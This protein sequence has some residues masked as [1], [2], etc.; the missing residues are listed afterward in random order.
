[1]TKVIKINPH[2]PEKDKI[3]QAAGVLQNGG[4]VIFPTETVYGVAANMQNAKAMDRLYKIK[5]RPKDKPFSIHIDSKEKVELYARDIPTS[6]YKLMNKFWP[7]PLTIILK[8]NSG[9]T[10]GFRL[11]DCAIATELIKNA[12]VAVVAPSANLS[13]SPA[14]ITFQDAIKDLEGKVDL[15]IDAGPAKIGLESSV[16]DLTCGHALVMREAAIKKED[17]EKV[18]N[19]KTV[20]FVCTGNTCRSVMAKYLM[21][22]ILKD[23]GRNDVEVSSAGILMMQGMGASFEVLNLLNKHNI[24]ASAHTTQRINIDLIRQS[25]LILVMEKIHE[26]EIAKI[27]PGEKKRVF[28]LKEFAKIDDSDLNIY[29]PIGKFPEFYEQAFYTIKE[30]VERVARIV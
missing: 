21:E 25:D 19:K 8:A 1:M 27:A 26:E 16:V 18:A 30:A 22:K 20:L 13:G 24:N 29:D 10:V 7:G 4:L 23:Q 11:P 9:G 14:P 2:N 17:I 28:L 12:G 5:Q 15:A 3:E 6:A